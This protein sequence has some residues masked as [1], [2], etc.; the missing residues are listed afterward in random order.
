VA[1]VLLESLL[2]EDVL[3]DQALIIGDGR[4]Y[5]TALIVPNWP[6]VRSELPQLEQVASDE[7]RDHADVLSLFERRINERLACV[8][9]YEQVRRFTL[10]PRPFTLDKHELT[11]K[12]SLR[13]PII[14]DHFRA[15]IEAMY[16]R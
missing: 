11:P 6:S 2:T 8:S 16:Q 1:P 3:I 10:L 14:Q 4:N 12:L 5:L 13:R 7:L 15:E 9:Y